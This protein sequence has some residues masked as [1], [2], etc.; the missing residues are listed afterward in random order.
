MAQDQI[1]KSNYHFLARTTHSTPAAAFAVAHQLGVAP[2]AIVAALASAQLPGARMR[3]VRTETLTIIDDCYNAGPDSMRAALETLREF[4][5]RGRRVVVLGAMRELGAHSDEQ[6]RKLGALAG[7]ICDFIVG[8]GS[9][10]EPMMD[11]LREGGQ[12]PAVGW[13]P[14]AAGAREVV[15]SRLQDGD[16]VLVKGSR[17]VGLE[18]VV[19]ALEER[20]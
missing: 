19:E 13:S 2:E 5:T 16:V 14:D 11:E 1:S 8:V 6:H 3:I 10:T 17:S 18:V 12:C 20:L 4:P 9:E 7:G 15:L